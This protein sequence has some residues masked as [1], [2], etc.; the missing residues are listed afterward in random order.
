MRSKKF[1][2]L[3]MALCLPLLA[4]CQP[5]APASKEKKDGKTAAG[6]ETT[7][8][9]EVTVDANGVASWPAVAPEYEYSIVDREFGTLGAQFT[10]DT[11]V[12]LPEGFSVHVCPLYENGSRGDIA[13]SAYYGE[14]ASLNDFT[15]EQL[16]AMGL[17]EA[18]EETAAQQ[19]S[20]RFEL[21]MDDTGNVTWNA[22]EGAV[23]YEITYAHRAVVVG[24]PRQIAE[25]SLRLPLH[26]AVSVQPVFADGTRGEAAHSE[27]FGG[28]LEPENTGVDLSA[29]SSYDFVAN[30]DRDSFVQ[31]ENGAAAF[32]S[33]GPDGQLMRFEAA[34]V[35][36]AENGL[37]LQPGAK[38]TALDA[39]GRIMGIRADIPDIG[40]EENAFDC[41]GE[42]AFDGAESVETAAQLVSGT[43]RGMHASAYADSPL[44]L[45]VGQPNYIS[46]GASSYNT[47]PLTVASVTVYYDPSDK[48]TDIRKIALSETEYGA[49][50]EGEKYDPSKEGR[51]DPLNG[52]FT[53]TL[54][55]E[56]DTET[57][58]VADEP[59][60]GIVGV[61]KRFFAVGDLKD[62][63]G[64]VLDK[65]NAVVE[66]GTVLEVTIGSYTC[67]VELPVVE[68]YTGANTMHD[69]VPEVY[70]DAAGDFAA[71]VVPITWQDEQHAYDDET[72]LAFKAELGR[73]QDEAGNFTDHSAQ[74]ADEKR[75]S[76]SE[77]FDTASY[78]KFRVSSFVTDWYPAQRTFEEARD[79]APDENFLNE[80][81]EW[82]YITYPDM[83]WGRFDRDGNGCFDTVIF[84]NAGGGEE[85]SS[86]NIIS[87]SGGVNSFRYYTD[88]G[89]GSAFRPAINQYILVHQ[90]LFKDQTLVHEFGHT[91]GL[92]DYY[93]VTYSGGNA[94]GEY[95]MQ[96]SNAGDWNAYS[97]YA[98]GWLEP[99]VVS[100]MAPGES[101][102]VTIGSMALTGDAI[103]IPAAEDAQAELPFG[104]YVIIDLFT[105]DG[106]HE[107]AAREYGL[108]DAA[109]V[110]IYHVNA[111]MERRELTHALAFGEAY[112]IGTVKNT[113]VVRDN[114]LG[115]YLIE[116]VQRGGNNTFTDLGNLRTRVK[117]SDFF[118]AGDVFTAESYDEFFYGGLMDS[119]LPFGY[120]VEVVSVDK[121]AK[122]AVIRITRN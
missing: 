48:T 104:E 56:P 35:S 37:V 79:M 7:A 62:A 105:D 19:E 99:T 18:A 72:M 55:V 47:S 83:D 36:L 112:P 64:N 44:D 50:L 27:A 70:P 25:T 10:Q 33:A 96:S 93:D 28:A 57:C 75:F 1:L 6:M 91:L 31:G 108:E 118:R 66:Q 82:L 39:I 42:Y 85:L 13:V 103:V 106:L 111:A 41:I 58:S 87:F 114:D 52:I 3:L 76:L 78:G 110:R 40:S 95:D 63:Q 5:A 107:Y 53:F 2:A 17:A 84:L 51:Y 20:G 74:L 68:R 4:S 45:S 46:V 120:T 14:P 49:Y 97:K 73:V 69:L 12:Q 116:L 23:A 59:M 65:E 80:V 77:Y 22:V 30:M 100:G 38:I 88:E 89:A 60:D 101:V 86:Y 98:A 94:V 121:E 92:V 102:E 21:T 54:H 11:F 122:Q 29:F 109:G 115:R 24:K 32:T 119:G 117:T 113:N 15:H 61:D 81:T 43:G 67:D 26:Y 9:F 90:H 71:L 8:V 34:G 16:I